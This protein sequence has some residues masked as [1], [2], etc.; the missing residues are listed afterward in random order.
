M[1]V[2]RNLLRSTIVVSLTAIVVIKTHKAAGPLLAKATRGVDV[3]STGKD[4]HEKGGFPT[5]AWG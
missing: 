3:Q 4:P 1:L 5:F 2:L